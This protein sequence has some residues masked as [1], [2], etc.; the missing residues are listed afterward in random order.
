MPWDRKRLL[1]YVET[2]QLILWVTDKASFYSNITFGCWISL[3]MDCDGT[4][5]GTITVDGTMTV[6]D[7]STTIL[8]L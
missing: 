2:I 6:T 7:F 8:E 4:A 1:G 5:D 3:V